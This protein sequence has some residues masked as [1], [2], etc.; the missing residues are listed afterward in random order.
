MVAKTLKQPSREK[1]R[2]ALDYSPETGKFVWKKKTGS[3]TVVGAEAGS[4]DHYGYVKISFEGVQHPAHYLAW[5]YVHDEWPSR[6]KHV[7]GQRADNRIDNLFVLNK[8]P[9]SGYDDAPA[10]SLKRLHEV[11]GY[12]PYTGIFV[13]K[14]ATSNRNPVG[15]VAGTRRKDNYIVICLDGRRYLAHRLAWFYVHEEW[16]END[17]DHKNHDPS[18]NSIVNLRKAT[19]GQ[20]TTNGTLRKDNKLGYVGITLLPSGRYRA[21]IQADGKP[22][23]IGVYDTLEEAVEAYKEAARRLHGEFAKA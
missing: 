10:P 14:I 16:P 19:R 6:V 18:N 13:W 15:S 17:V 7:N 1:L 8:D 21:S 11:L 3:R 23:H 2:D 12:D 5:L 22:L 20:N 9:E 4:V